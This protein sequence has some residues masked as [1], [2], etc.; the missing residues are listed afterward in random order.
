M[1]SDFGVNNNLFNSMF[2][3]SAAGSSTGGSSVLGDYAMIRSGSYKKLL[4]A[5]YSEDKST[6]NSTDST[7]ETTEQ[8]AEKNAI[9][10]VKTAAAN[11]K[12]AAAALSGAEGEDR[13]EK[14][15]SFVKAYNDFLESTDNEDMNNEKI[16][17][18]TLWMI[19][20][21]KVNEGLLGKAGISIGTD[22]KLTLNEEKFKA[23]DDSV[24]NTL[25]KGRNSL[26]GKVSSKTFDISNRATEAITKMNGGSVYTSKGDYTKLN[27][28]TLYD[29]LF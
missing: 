20:D 5:Y 8:K 18:K 27:T 11:L 12:D 21:F 13:L 19:K 15:K 24:L 25:F 9:M 6:Q 1:T 3:T 7:K 28:K 17:Q 2:G 22:N 4:K 26:M 23:A 14:A 16:L 10:G 29:E